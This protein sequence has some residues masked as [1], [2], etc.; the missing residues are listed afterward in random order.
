[1]LP[2]ADIYNAS[3]ASLALFNKIFHI[4]PAR[5]IFTSKKQIFEA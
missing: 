4:L 1:M 5:R 2:G 3:P